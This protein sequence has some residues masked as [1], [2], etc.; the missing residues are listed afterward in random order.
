LFSTRIAGDH[1]R[2][3]SSRIQ[4]PRVVEHVITSKHAFTKRATQTTVNFHSDGCLRDVSF[5][6]KGRIGDCACFF[7]SP[8]PLLL[9]LSLCW[10]HH[11]K[12]SSS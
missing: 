9:H 4:M 8:H 2:S 5:I 11:N 6:T 3:S 12:R 10:A 7:F 1:R